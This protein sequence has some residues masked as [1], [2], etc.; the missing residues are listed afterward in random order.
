MNKILLN[1]LTPLLKDKVIT[2]M[3][4][5]YGLKDH[6]I[7]E[8]YLEKENIIHFDEPVEKLLFLIEGKAKVTMVHEDGKR[9]II[10]F[11]NPMELIG[12]L[13]LIE[14]DDQPKDIEAVTSCICLSMP[15]ELAKDVLLKDSKFLLRLSRYIGQKLLTGTWF[16]MKFQNYELKN[17]LAAYMLMSQNNGIYNEKH[18]ETAEFL[19]VS[20]RHLLY[21]F[22]LFLEEG[23]I[24]KTTKGFLLNLEELEILS[25]DIL[26]DVKTT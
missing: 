14:V 18:I 7:I 6:I 17:R 3:D 25:M 11:L 15:L 19:G 1:E 24:E 22:K 5:F 16:Q 21:T 23:V 4:I 8:E 20:Y 2:S 9:S 12:E 13:S 10:R 26:K